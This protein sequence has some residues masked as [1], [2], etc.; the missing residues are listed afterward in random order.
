AGT[1]GGIFWLNLGWAGV[2]AFIA[3]LLLLALYVG[4]RLRKLPEAAKI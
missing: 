3:T 2:V 1:L 4:Q